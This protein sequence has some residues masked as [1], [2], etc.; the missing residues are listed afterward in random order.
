MSKK[1]WKQTVKEFDGYTCQIC[2]EVHE[3]GLT[4]H[5]IRH[6]IDGGMNDLNNLIS[7]CLECHKVLHLIAP[8]RVDPTIY[9]EE[10]LETKDKENNRKIK[11]SYFQRLE[12]LKNSL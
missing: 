8:S 6:K 11:V 5:H 4:V 10:V 9:T 12:K 1:E 7:L 3:K 2:G